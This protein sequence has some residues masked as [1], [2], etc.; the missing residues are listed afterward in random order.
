[1]RRPKAR[2]SAPP[3]SPR[4]C[5]SAGSAATM[6]ISAIGSISFAATARAAARTRGGWRSAG[7]MMRR[8]RRRDAVR[9]FGRRDPVAGLSRP[10]R[11]EPRRE[12]RV[13][14]G[15]RPRRQC[16]SGVRAGAR[17]VP[18]RGRA[19]RHRRAEP[20]S[21]RRPDH[22]GRDRAALRRTA[23]N[24]ARTSPSMPRREAC[25]AAAA[26]GSVRSRWPSGRMPVTPGPEAAKQ[27][28]DG[29]VRLGLDRLPWT[30]SLQQWRDRVMFLRRAGGDEWPD[31]SDDGARRERRRLACAAARRQD[32]AG[33]RFG[34]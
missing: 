34:R 21:A 15:Q 26:N 27:L 23:S 29:I 22:A 8:R 11:Q 24:A 32:H 7:R 6:S 17:A 31:L 14:S 5:R 9:S 13:P 30:K 18:R 28:A 19:C 3:T 10:H 20:H 12:R 25:A 16:R 4:S 33:V 2:A 1:M